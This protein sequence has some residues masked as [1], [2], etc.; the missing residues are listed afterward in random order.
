MGW[1]EPIP[2]PCKSRSLVP[3]PSLSTSLHA[4]RPLGKRIPFGTT[5]SGLPPPPFHAACL[6]S[7]SSS[8]SNTGTHLAAHGKFH[9]RIKWG[10]AMEFNE[11]TQQE[12]RRILT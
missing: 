6:A 11:K 12:T 2:P 4:A 3:P 5:P 10:E 9:L 8:T 1:E 7:A